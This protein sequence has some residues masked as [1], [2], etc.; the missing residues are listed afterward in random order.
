MAKSGGRGD[1]LLD[2]AVNT[3]TLGLVKR[4]AAASGCSILF[5]QLKARIL[6]LFV[7]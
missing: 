7:Q 4:D 1:N 2:V 6:Q 3:V 5:F